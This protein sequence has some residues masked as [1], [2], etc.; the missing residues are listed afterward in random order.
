MGMPVGF[1]LGDRCL[2]VRRVYCH[3]FELGKV[4]PLKCCL[5]T[6]TTWGELTNMGGNLPQKLAEF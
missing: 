3:P 1:A 2:L 6:L 5:S 4:H